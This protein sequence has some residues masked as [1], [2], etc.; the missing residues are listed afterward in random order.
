[1]KIPAH[2][3]YAR[4]EM[5]LKQKF[6]FRLRN[7]DGGEEIILNYLTHHT[8]HTH[9]HHSARLFTQHGEMTHSIYGVCCDVS[10]L[11]IACSELNCPLIAHKL[12][13]MRIDFPL[14]EKSHTCGRQFDALYKSS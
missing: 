12:Q 14:L 11:V 6:H 2:F 1:M 9:P 3:L 4:Y 7:G 13:Q 5:L 8:A 10:G